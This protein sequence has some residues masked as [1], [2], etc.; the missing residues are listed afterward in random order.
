QRRRSYAVTVA[1]SEDNASTSVSDTQE[2]DEPAINGTR[3]RK[4]AVKGEDGDARV[5]V[6][7][8]SHANGVEPAGDFSATVDW[9]VAGHTADAGTVTQDGSGTYHVSALR[10]V[11]SEDGSYAVT[12]A[13]GEDNVSTSVTDTQEVDEPAINGT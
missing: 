5:E 3:D 7:T 9:G 10:P 12:V 6:A 11:F 1:I 8:F 4:S 13:I 2:V